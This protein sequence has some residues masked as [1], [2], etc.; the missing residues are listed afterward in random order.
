MPQ[1]AKHIEKSMA[2]TGREYREVHEWIDDPQK[3]KDRHDVTQVM[4]LG[5]MFREK[6]GEEASPKPRPLNWVFR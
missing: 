6:Y 2:R 1:V 5:Q 4:E 3:K